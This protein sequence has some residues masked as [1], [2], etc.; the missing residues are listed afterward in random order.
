MCVTRGGAAGS[1]LGDSHTLAISSRSQIERDFG[2]TVLDEAQINGRLAHQLV[3][4]IAQCQP[5]D[6]MERVHTRLAR[7]SVGGAE[8]G[9]N[10]QQS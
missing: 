3:T 10:T 5:E 6:I 8:R 7:V 2:Q 1:Y 9:A 4:L